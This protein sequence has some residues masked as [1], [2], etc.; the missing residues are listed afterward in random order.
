MS[1][2]SSLKIPSAAKILHLD[3]SGRYEN[4]VSRDLSRSFV[5]TLKEQSP[6]TEVTYRDLLQSLPHV[7][8]A[9]ITANFTP[10]DERT[11][12]QKQ[13][14]ALSDSL[15][16][17]LLDNDIIIMGVPLY[18]FSVPAALKAWIDMV[19]RAQLTFRYTENGPEGLL[20]NKKAYIIMTT[21][22]VA[23]N[24]ETDFATGYLKHVLSFL[25]IHDVEVIKAD[26]LMMEGESKIN[27]AQAAINLLAH[28]TVGA[29][30]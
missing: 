17:E 7:D 11:A 10:A 5:E 28:Q 26:M 19:A 4:S 23:V 2:S 8:E 1:Q 21:G 27:Q 29:A 30:A 22:G 18:N 24:S 3:S 6:E 13:T 25:G 12:E 9:W 16:Q 14:L 20:K 15:V